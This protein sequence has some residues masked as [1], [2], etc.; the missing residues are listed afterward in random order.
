MAWFASRCRMRWMTSL[1]LMSLAFSGCGDDSN[2]VHPESCAG[3]GDPA[4]SCSFAGEWVTPSGEKAAMAWV[5]AFDLGGFRLE[6]GERRKRPW[7]V[8]WAPHGATTDA[9]AGDV[10]LVVGGADRPFDATL[11]V[12]LLDEGSTLR[13]TAVSGEILSPNSTFEGAYVGP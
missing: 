3:L 2:T 12:Q 10:Q 1:F 11:E 6:L 13:V 7:Y 5:S 4:V 8:I 9:F